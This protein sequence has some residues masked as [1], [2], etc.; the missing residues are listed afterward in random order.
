MYLKP[1]KRNE[2]PSPTW[3]PEPTWKETPTTSIPRARAVWRRGK[4]Q[5]GCAPNCCFVVVVGVVWVCMVWSVP[6]VHACAATNRP[7]D[8]TGPTDPFDQLTH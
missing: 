2:S 6:C 3:Q 4:V 1:S 5:G 7:V 8:Q